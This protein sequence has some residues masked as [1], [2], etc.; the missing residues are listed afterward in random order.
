MTES[1]N[2]RKPARRVLAPPVAEPT[3]RHEIAVEINGEMIEAEVESRLLL[4]DFLRDR[5]R[6][7]GTHIGCEQGSCGACTVLLDDLPVRSCLMLAPQVDGR[8]VRTVEGLAAPDGALSP[9]QQA[10]CDHHGLQCGFCTPGFLMTLTSLAERETP[11]TLGE[12]DHHL[13]SSFCRCTGYVNIR[14]AAR[15]AL[16]LAPAEPQLASQSTQGESR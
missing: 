1:T 10:F 8:S 15:H 4:T 2:Q 5:V 13:D 14:A 9:M 6:L 7:T 12:L 11:V 16:G 3:T